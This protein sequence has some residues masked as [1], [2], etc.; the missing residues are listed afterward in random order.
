M[1]RKKTPLSEINEHSNSGMLPECRLLF[2]KRELS[3]TASLLLWG[4]RGFASFVDK[5]HKEIFRIRV[6]GFTA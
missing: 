4:Q 6:T 3:W 2:T 5:T 1:A